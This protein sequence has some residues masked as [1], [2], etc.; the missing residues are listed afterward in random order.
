MDEQKVREIVKESEDRLREALLEAM[1][2]MQTELLRA[3]HTYAH[4]V[5]SVEVVYPEY[6]TGV[7]R[8]ARKGL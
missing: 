4:G 8:K 6:E 5:S 2:E 1:R 3:F 7:Q